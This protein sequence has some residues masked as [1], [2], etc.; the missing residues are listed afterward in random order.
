MGMKTKGEQ[1]TAVDFI[2]KAI[3]IVGLPQ[4]Y[5]YSINVMQPGNEVT[6]Q[7]RYRSDSIVTL[8]R[9]G[10][11]PKIEKSGFI[12]AEVRGG[13]NTPAIRIVLT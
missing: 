10:F 1:M 11:S 4:E 13:E 8:E 7:G 6:L 9:K 3:E 12:V 2:L 5:F